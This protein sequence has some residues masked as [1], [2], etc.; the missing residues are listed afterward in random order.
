MYYRLNEPY[1]FR[2]YKG[3]PYA[4]R[5]ERGKKL[6]DRPLFFG[7]ERFLALLYCNGTEPVEPEALDEKTRASF[8]ELLSRGVLTASEAPM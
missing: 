6:F 2:G 1:A 8:Q 7:K 4:I 5:A 3:L